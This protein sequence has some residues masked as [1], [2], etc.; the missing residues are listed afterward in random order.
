MALRS[1]E[2]LEANKGV[3]S[4]NENL[5]NG[6]IS[7][8][9]FA[10]VNARRCAMKFCRFML[11]V[12]V[13]AL[14]ASVAK[15]DGGDP[16][17]R[18]NTVVD[19]PCAEGVIC[20]DNLSDFT[21]SLP[22]GPFTDTIVYTGQDSVTSLQLLFSDSD[23][24]S[25]VVQSDIFADVSYLPEVN[26]NELFLL[27]ILTGSGPCTDNG[28]NTPPEN[29]PGVINPG[30]SFTFS[31]P[32]GFTSPQTL[33]FSPEPSGAVLSLTG[34]VLLLGFGISRKRA[35]ATV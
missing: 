26:N 2:L 25:I 35:T 15:A 21:L 5:G 10:A 34:L 20:I 18:I 9:L 14:G 32:D 11:A 22:A 29:C 12:A 33:S 8:V 7:A 3:T 6:T 24:E 19:P 16:T 13:I 27:A 4:H 23:L 30:D 28:A 1:E 31:S 17:F